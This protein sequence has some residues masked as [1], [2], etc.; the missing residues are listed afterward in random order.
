MTSRLLQTRSSNDEIIVIAGDTIL[1][2]QRYQSS[3]EWGG[4]SDHRLITCKG[5]RPLAVK[6]TYDELL[7]FLRGLGYHVWESPAEAIPF[8]GQHIAFVLEHVVGVMD[9][10]IRTEMG[11]TGPIMIFHCNGGYTSWIVNG[12]MADVV[13]KLGALGMPKMTYGWEKCHTMKYRVE[14]VDESVVPGG[15]TFVGSRCFYQDG[16]GTVRVVQGV[17]HI[18]FP[19]FEI[20]GVLCAG[21]SPRDLG[22]AIKRQII[23]RVY[24]LED[25]VT[26]N[27]SGPCEG[28]DLDVPPNVIVIAIRSI[29]HIGRSYVCTLGMGCIREDPV[30]DGSDTRP[31]GLWLDKLPDVESFEEWLEGSGDEVTRILGSALFG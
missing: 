25:A 18:H 16:S 9:A 22:L 1:A 13:A 15:D 27:A 19:V 14:F 3:D 24:E 7:A 28:V 29:R 8:Q 17:P 11:D 20:Q 12:A 6:A 2:V 30:R 26:D 5:C 10:G 21:M 23:S 31:I 4:V